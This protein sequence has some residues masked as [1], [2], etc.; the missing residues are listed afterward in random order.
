M[1][2]PLSRS[3]G[4]ATRTSG[5]VGNLS[6]EVLRFRGE[7]VGRRA[8]ALR[9]STTLALRCPLG[10]QICGLHDYGALPR[11]Q[12]R[13]SETGPTPKR[14]RPEHLMADGAVRLAATA[15]S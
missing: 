2:P 15:I 14:S 6:D 11:K 10:K 13:Q 7:R 1:K 12:F 3:G 9:L 8:L 5:V 4:K